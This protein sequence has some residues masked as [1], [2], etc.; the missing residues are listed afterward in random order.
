MLII[1]QKII[2]AMLLINAVLEYDAYK[3]KIMQYVPEAFILN[4]TFT[5]IALQLKINFNSFFHKV[6]KKWRKKSIFSH[7][8]F[9]T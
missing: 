8:Q 1:I 6:E 7:Y 2:I 5:L 9:A 4:L 3:I